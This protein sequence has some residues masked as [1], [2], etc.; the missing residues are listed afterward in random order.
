MIRVAV[1][2]AAN[3]LFMSLPAQANVASTY[4][5][6]ESVDLCEVQLLQIEYEARYMDG[7][8]AWRMVGGVSVQNGAA[9]S[10]FWCE[11]GAMYRVNG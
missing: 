5:V 8:E 10:D 7:Y 4:K 2:A 1:M 3:I 9:W 6:K 11:G